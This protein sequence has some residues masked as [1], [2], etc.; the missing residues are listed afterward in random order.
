MLCCNTL[1]FSQLCCDRFK[2]III[3]VTDQREMRLSM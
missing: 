2:C 1:V 3:I